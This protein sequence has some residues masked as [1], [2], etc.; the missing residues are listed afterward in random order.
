VL[1]SSVQAC[2]DVWLRSWPST[3]IPVGRVLNETYDAET[4]TSESRD[5]GVTRPRHSRP[6]LQPCLSEHG[7]SVTSRQLHLR[8][9]RHWLVI[10]G[11][12]SDSRPMFVAIVRRPGTAGHTRTLALDAF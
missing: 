12:P 11:I 1:K 10:W 3:S 2:H 9:T 5:F 7:L 4:E 6:S 8:F